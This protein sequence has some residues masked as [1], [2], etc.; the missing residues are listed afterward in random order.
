MSGRSTKRSGWNKPVM[1][2][3]RLKKYFSALKEFVL[4]ILFP[5]ECLGCGKEGEWICGH[6]EEKVRLDIYVGKGIFLDKI[7][8][9]YSYDNPIIKQS[10]HLFKYKNIEE[11]GE[12]LGKIFINGL[13]KIIRKGDFEA[14]C[15]PI[16][17][18]EKRLR[19]RGFNQSEILAIRVG[20]FF[21]WE[22]SSAIISRFRFTRPQ[23]GLNEEER[24][25]N[26]KD[27]FSVKDNKIIHNKRIILIDDVFTTGATMEECAKA[28]KEAGAGEVWGLAL[29]KG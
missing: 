13:N 15:V 8:V 4:D 18:H 29:A 20:D 2:V 11:L 6:C 28:L 12:V 23:V 27:A 16:P 21:L 25:E 22:I 1:D 24:K 9:P 26:I 17:L 7:I 5:V 14:A 3:S 19:E 10:I